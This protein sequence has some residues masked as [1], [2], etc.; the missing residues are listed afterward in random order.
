MKTLLK[1]KLQRKILVEQQWA[2]KGKI[3]LQASQTSDAH[4]GIVMALCCVRACVCVCVCGG[5]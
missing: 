1:M 4:A 5:G 2:Q 3:E